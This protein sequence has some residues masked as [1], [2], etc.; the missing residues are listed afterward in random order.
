MSQKALLIWSAV[1]LLSACNGKDSLPPVRN[2][3][4][5]QT[6]QAEQDASVKHCTEESLPFVIYRADKDQWAYCNAGK[7]EMIN[8]PHEVLPE[9]EVM[10][11]HHPDPHGD[12]AVQVPAPSAHASYQRKDKKRSA[13]LHI[14]AD[15]AH[16]SKERVQ[17]TSGT[18][19]CQ[20]DAKIPQSFHCRL[21]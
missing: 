3:G 20:K 7:F 2:E 21:R 11:Q 18:F 6:E 9:L 17:K 1:G 4:E 13:H 19:F 8:H 14:S 5:L 16:L 10:E 15:E 12:A